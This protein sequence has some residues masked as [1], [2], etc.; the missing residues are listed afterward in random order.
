M[1]VILR[2][3]VKEIEKNY[4]VK[5][6]GKKFGERKMEINKPNKHSKALKTRMRVCDRCDNLYPSTARRGSFCPKCIFPNKKQKTK[7]GGI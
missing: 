4:L 3:F 6:Q 1:F 7:G 5:I 2:N